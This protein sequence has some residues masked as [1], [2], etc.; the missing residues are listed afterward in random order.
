[1]QAPWLRAILVDRGVVG[2]VV[3]LGEIAMDTR[4]ELRERARQILVES[5][6]LGVRAVLVAAW[7]AGRNWDEVRQALGVFRQAEGPDV[8]GLA[9]ECFWEHMD[10]HPQEYS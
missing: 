9:I 10:S 5:V 4:E 3:F 2:L 8:A 7:R 6:P 1:L